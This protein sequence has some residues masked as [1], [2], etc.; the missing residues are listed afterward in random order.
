MCMTSRESARLCALGRV[1]HREDRDAIQARIRQ[2]GSRLERRWHLKPGPLAQWPRTTTDNRQRW[3]KAK[4]AECHSHVHSAAD[5]R[6]RARPQ[7]IS[8]R[9]RLLARRNAAHRLSESVCTFSRR[10]IRLTFDDQR[11]CISWSEQLRAPT[12]TASAHAC[13]C[14]ALLWRQKRGHCAA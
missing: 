11:M 10:S 12:H 2:A 14:T 1:E 9:G 8:A 6:T 3:P 13:A 5:R 7:L 4:R